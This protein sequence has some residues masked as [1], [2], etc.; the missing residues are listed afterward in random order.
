MHDEQRNGVCD[1]VELDIVM[2]PVC[3]FRPVVWVGVNEAEYTIGK[4][5]PVVL[6]KIQSQCMVQRPAQKF[7]RAVFFTGQKNRQRNA[8]P[9]GIGNDDTVFLCCLCKNLCFCRWMSCITGQFTS[10]ESQTF[11]GATEVKQASGVYSVLVNL[12]M[13]LADS[14]QRIFHAMQL[15]IKGHQVNPSW[16]RK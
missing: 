16:Y 3:A 7:R 1:S 9:R 8:K 6:P 11:T 13:K 12:L 15:P 10:D 4:R 2:V 5:R 14:L